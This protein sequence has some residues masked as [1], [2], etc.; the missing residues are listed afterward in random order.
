L[1]GAG[2]EFGD[3]RLRVERVVGGCQQ[4]GKN[5]RIPNVGLTRALR[6]CFTSIGLAATTRSA[7]GSNRSYTCQA[8]VIDSMTT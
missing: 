4:S 8:F 5:E 6:I 2:F 7:N 1:H 3:L